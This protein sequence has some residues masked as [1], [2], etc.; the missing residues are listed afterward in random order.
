LAGK[1]QASFW[2]TQRRLSRPIFSI[3]YNRD[4]A[5]VVAT[6]GEEGVIAIIFGGRAFYVFEPAGEPRSVPFE[7]VTEMWFF[8]D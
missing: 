5:E 4:G 6:V 7:T 2:P 3:S 8:D 1:L